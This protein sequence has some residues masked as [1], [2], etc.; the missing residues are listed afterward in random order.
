[1]QHKY[2]PLD[3]N[4]LLESAQLDSERELI[5]ELIDFT[6]QFYLEYR[7]P[8]GL[9]D[10]TIRAIKNHKTVYTSRLE[11]FYRNLAGIYRYKYGQ[12]QLEFLFD[13]LD[14]RTKYKQDWHTTY[15]KWLIEFCSKP[16]FIKAVLELTVFYPEEKKSLLA[17]NRMKVFLTQQFDLK[18]YKYK[19]IQ[20]VA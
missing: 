9:E 11:E 15:R 16:S 7:N 5:I 6:K 2:F 8:L 10:D 4:Y 1:M 13:G 20:K 12:N 19:G 17:E 3:K 18:V 14:H